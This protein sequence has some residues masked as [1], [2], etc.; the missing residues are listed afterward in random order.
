MGLCSREQPCFAGRAGM[1]GSLEAF[2]SGAVGVLV[3]EE[4]LQKKAL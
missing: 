3:I 1:A 2:F 4:P